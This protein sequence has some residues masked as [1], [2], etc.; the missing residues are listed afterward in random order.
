MF[1][2]NVFSKISAYYTRYNVGCAKI[3][4]NIGWVLYLNAKGYF[5]LPHLSVY[6]MAYW[7]ERA[8]LNNGSL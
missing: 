8:T 1:G 2:Y 3:I 5:F 4:L 6:T 7:G